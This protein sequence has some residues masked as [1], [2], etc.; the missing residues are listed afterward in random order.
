MNIT[1][2]S[3]PAV[4][5][6]TRLNRAPSKK[7]QITISLMAALLALLASASPGTA[8]TVAPDLGAAQRFAVLAGTAVTCTDSTVTGDVGIYPGT[9]TET[10][11]SITGTIDLGAQTA[12]EDF[13][14]TYVALAFAPCDVVVTGRLAGQ[15]LSPGTYCLDAAV[16]ETGGVLTLKGDSNGVWIIKIGTLGTGALAATDFSVVMADGGQASNVYWW[17]AQ[18]ATLTDSNFRGTILAGTSITVTRGSLD[19]KALAGT[20]VTMTGAA[21]AAPTPTPTPTPTPVMPTNQAPVDLGSAGSFVI[22][23]KS[24]IT[25]VPT[26]AITGNIG[27]S[28]ITGAAMTGLDCAEVTGT[29]YTVD[30]AG[31]ACRVENAVLLAAAV[32]DMETAYTDAAGRVSPDAT[33]LGAGNIDGMTLIPGLYKWGTPVLIPTRVTLD[34]QGDTNAVFI[35]QIAQGLTVGN[36]AV[37]TLSGGAQA[38]NIFWQVAGQ[39]TLGTTADFKG[40]VLCATA[41]VLNTGASMDGRAL[42]QTAVTLQMN[43]VTEPTN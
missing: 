29:I 4:S 25:D 15:T 14:R 20:A 16:A 22:L 8:A 7:R 42:A 43:A 9:V 2:E 40:I 23:S 30:A 18:A 32:S 3:K 31:P 24:G 39:T 33:E 6:P 34:A 35:F 21:L 28:P 11:S 36:G 19:G 12:N 27:T 5:A 13:V 1:Q 10:R 38:R 17:V 37:V 26:S 41:I